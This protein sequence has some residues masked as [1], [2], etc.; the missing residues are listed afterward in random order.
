[1]IFDSQVMKKLR[2]KYAQLPN[3]EIPEIILI[4]KID[5]FENERNCLESLISEVRKEKQQDWLGRL[6]NLSDNQ[7]FSA[8][9][10]IRLFGWLREHFAVEV[11]PAIDNCCPDFSLD[12]PNSPVIIEAKAYI[13][14]P[15]EKARNR[16]LSR[17]IS[18]L[19]CIEKSYFIHFSIQRLGVS[20]DK[21]NLNKT[22]SRWLDSPDDHLL[23]EDDQGNVIEF[24]D[25]RKSEL[26]NVC[27]SCSTAFS[28]ISDVLK[29]ALREKAHQHKV[30][31]HSGYPYIIALFIEPHNLS[32][33]EVVSAWLGNPVVV[34]DRGGGGIIETR[35]DY[36]GIHFFG[37]EIRHKSVSGTLVFTTKLNPDKK[38]KELSTAYIQNPFAEI[39][40]PI[41]FFP[42]ESRFVVI[43]KTEKNF[44]MD[45]Q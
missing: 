39:P 36:S 34:V 29:P 2:N 17:I 5:E 24:R 44:V 7:F 18:F 3:Y 22:V 37:R 38:M 13:S 40:F 30:L 35:T 16:N 27:V 15:D 14:P 9:F 42:V 21:E 31:R 12:Y 10:E 41:D 25:K 6:V 1:M 28:I 8:W 32:A 4:D 45:W 23:Y 43:A 26:E 19:G 20:V 33:R 11:A